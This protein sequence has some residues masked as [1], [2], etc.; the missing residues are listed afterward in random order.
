[1][2]EEDP[3]LRIQIWFKVKT[4]TNDVYC[5]FHCLMMIAQI[6]T[7]NVAKLVFQKSRDVDVNKCFRMNI[8]NVNLDT[9]H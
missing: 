7:D 3:H 5:I 6:L 8:A 9:K 4:Y 1:M 2:W